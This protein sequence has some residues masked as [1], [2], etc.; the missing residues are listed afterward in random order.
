MQT[1][2]RQIGVKLQ[3]N[4][5]SVEEGTPSDMTGF[6]SALADDLNT[7]NAL[8]ELFKVLKEGNTLLRTREIDF[9]R[10]T[11][12]FFSLKDMLSILGLELE[13]PI[14]TEEDKELFKEY[15][16]SKANKDFAKSDEIRKVLIEKHLM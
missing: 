2:Y 3:L 15:D 11:G 14:L 1:A 7:S 8:S 12:V 4:N 13:L 6:I 16:L 9:E 10:L 5:I